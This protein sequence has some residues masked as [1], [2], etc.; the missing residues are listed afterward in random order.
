MHV[1][2]F[3]C[4]WGGGGGGREVRWTPLL[5]VAVKEAEASRNGDRWEDS[6]G[7][8]ITASSFSSV[9]PSLLTGRTRKMCCLFPKQ[10]T[11]A[12]ASGGHQHTSG[13]SRAISKSPSD[14]RSFR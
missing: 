6:E 13:W 14:S 5:S 4:V 7:G 11:A 3:V 12:S 10:T 1:C 2:V 9:R 8:I